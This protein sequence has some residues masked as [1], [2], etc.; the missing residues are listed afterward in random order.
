MNLRPDQ[1][2]TLDVL[3]EATPK[4]VD[5]R[6]VRR[7]ILKTPG[8]VDVHDLH[9]WSITSG[10]NVLSAHVVIDGRADRKSV[11]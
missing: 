5:L 3:L 6:E 7:H 10:M 11:V 8:V 9:A 1:V 4:S 2:E